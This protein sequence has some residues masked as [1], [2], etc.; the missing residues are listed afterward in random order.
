MKFVADD[1]DF[2]YRYLVWG[3]IEPRGKQ[4]KWPKG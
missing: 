3:R 1:D 2:L 4:L